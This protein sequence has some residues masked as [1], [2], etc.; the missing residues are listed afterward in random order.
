ML[1]TEDDERIRKVRNE[2]TASRARTL[3]AKTSLRFN[4]D[5]DGTFDGTF[6]AGL[7]CTQEVVGQLAYLYSPGESRTKIERHLTYKRT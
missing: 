5:F 3:G 6:A 4:S 1:R 7:N 2:R